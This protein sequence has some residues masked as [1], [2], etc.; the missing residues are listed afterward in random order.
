VTSTLTTRRQ[1]HSAAAGGSQTQSNRAIG[2]IA[3]EIDL[4]SRG[5][6]RRERIIGAYAS[7]GYAIARDRSAEP[8]RLRGAVPL[9]AGSRD[10]GRLVDGPSGILSGEM[11]NP[12]PDRG[13]ESTPGDSRT[14]A[15]SDLVGLRLTL[16]LGVAIVAI[17]AVFFF[18]GAVAGI[19][20][21]LTAV[22]L[23]IVAFVAAIRRADTSD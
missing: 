19:I 1:R 20:V 16:Y 2:L 6:L 7:S 21:L 9:I 10:R 22:V 11:A 12:A 3:Y 17:L 13:P 18:V 14:R 4:S 5:Q 8:R 15:S 23:G